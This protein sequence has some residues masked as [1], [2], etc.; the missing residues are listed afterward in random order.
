MHTSP[1]K[2]GIKGVSW[3]S[4]F[5][6]W[7]VRIQVQIDGTM[8]YASFGL[9]DDLDEA[10][11]VAR[12]ARAGLIE[13]HT[14]TG[15]RSR[16]PVPKYSTRAGLPPPDLTHVSTGDLLDELHRRGALK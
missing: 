1:P 11:A 5:G 12:R 9:Y 16:I 8:R 2:S 13:P 10:A 6:K 4:Q 3:N 7:H 14:L 15:T